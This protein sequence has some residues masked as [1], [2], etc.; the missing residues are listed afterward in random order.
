M[1]KLLIILSLLASNAA[2]AG[3]NH[4]PPPAPE[5]TPA[6][7]S[8]PKDNWGGAELHIGVSAVVGLGCRAYFEGS[9]NANVKAFGCAMVPG[10]IKEAIDSRSKGNRFSTK[11]L[12]ADALGAAIG[13][14]VGNFVITPNSIT[15]QKSF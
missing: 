9:E 8:K 1:K 5:P 15:Y 13:V 3:G 12:L 6:P 11:D 2:F 4:T 14:T 10:L 7:V